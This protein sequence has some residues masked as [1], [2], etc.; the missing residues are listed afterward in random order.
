MIYISST[1]N[2]SSHLFSGIVKNFYNSFEMVHSDSLP[3]LDHIVAYW[4]LNTAYEIECVWMTSRGGETQSNSDC[5]HDP[6][7]DPDAVFMQ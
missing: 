6:D 1:K 3:S 5:N 7:A 2:D 4:L